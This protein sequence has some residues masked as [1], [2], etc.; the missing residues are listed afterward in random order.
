ME[1]SEVLAVGQLVSALGTVLGAIETL[2]TQLE[3]LRGPQLNDEHGLVAEALQAG[4]QAAQ[5]ARAA[6]QAADG[7][8]MA[9]RVYAD[10]RRTLETSVSLVDEAIEHHIWGDAKP[11]DEQDCSYHRYV[12]NTRSLLEAL[13]RIAHP[14]PAAIVA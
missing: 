3:Q 12:R 5:R 10:V 14:V 11:V 8:V 9:G 1:R 6:L 13:E 4:Q 7:V 2:S